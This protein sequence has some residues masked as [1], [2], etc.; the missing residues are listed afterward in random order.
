[1]AFAGKATVTS[2]KQEEAGLKGLYDENEDVLDTIHKMSPA[3]LKAIHAKMDAD[4]DGHVIAEEMDAYAHDMRRKIANKRLDGII[5]QHDKNKDGILDLDE[6]LSDLTSQHVHPDA[7]PGH[8]EITQKRMASFK[9]IDLN[10]DGF[11]D[12]DEL[13]LRFH[14]HTNDLV[15]DRMAAISMKKKDANGDGKLTNVEFWSHM[16]GRGKPSKVTDE[17]QKE[18]DEID[19]DSSG[20]L[21]LIEVRNYESGHFHTE[22]AMAELFHV[23][24][25]NKDKKLTS[26]ELV[27]S[28]KQKIVNLKHGGNHFREWHTH[29][30]L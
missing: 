6:Y 24:D 12:R 22:I 5:K 30:E 20:F 2:E 16:Y 1:M 25:G 26:D 14:H 9:E 21:E 23:V 19:K 29:G 10:N 3:Q 17:Q 15:D 4:G 7:R 8:E 18:F 11:V 27:K 28:N 13:P